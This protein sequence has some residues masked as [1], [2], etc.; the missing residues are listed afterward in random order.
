VNGKY[1]AIEDDT[2][3]KPILRALSQ[4]VIPESNIASRDRY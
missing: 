3:S 4:I 1:K 2:C